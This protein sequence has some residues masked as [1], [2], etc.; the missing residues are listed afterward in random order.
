MAK[1]QKAETGVNAQ[2]GGK[3]SGPH[4][5]DVHVGSRV[6]LRRMIL[7]M[8]Q[9]SLGKSLGLTFQQ[10]QKYEK[11]VNRI[12]A[13]RMFELSQLLEVPVQFFYDEYGAGADRAPGFAETGG[14]EVMNLLNSPEGVQL[15]RYFSGIRDPEVKKRVLELV[16]SIAETEESGVSAPSSG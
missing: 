11:G 2:E 12:G 1:P 3:R 6:K 15:C 8:S 14:G 9:E 4:P 13:S 16:R 10:I 7:G 5:I